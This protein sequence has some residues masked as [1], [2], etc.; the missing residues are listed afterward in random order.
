MCHRRR[1]AI[2]MYLDDG[3]IGAIVIRRRLKL[4]YLTAVLMIMSEVWLF[5]NR[6]AAAAA[7][8]VSVYFLLHETVQGV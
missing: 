5:V 2:S 7:A 1:A 6:P 4:S 3:A 8:A